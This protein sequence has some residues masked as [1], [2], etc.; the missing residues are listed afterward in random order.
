M[1]NENQQQ[2]FNLSDEDS[3]DII[4]MEELLGQNVEPPVKK[5]EEPINLDD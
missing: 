3:S 4:S 1:I 5:E 2:Q